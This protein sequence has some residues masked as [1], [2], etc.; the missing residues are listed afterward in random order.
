MIARLLALAAAAGLLLVMVIVATREPQDAAAVSALLLGVGVVAFAA[1]STIFYYLPRPRPRRRRSGLIALRRGALVGV[2][3]GALGLL[4]VA[5]ALSAVTAAFLV[6]A[7][8][9]LEALLS[10]RG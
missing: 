1:A 10:A 8:A 2:G 6:V 4:R 5:D 7:L 9:A 3:V